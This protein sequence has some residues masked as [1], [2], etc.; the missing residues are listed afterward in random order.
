MLEQAP[1]ATAAAATTTPP[2]EQD[3]TPAA[4]TTQREGDRDPYGAKSF[5]A[6]LAPYDL[7]KIGAVNVM[8]IPTSIAIEALLIPTVRIPYSL[9]HKDEPWIYIG[10]SIQIGVPGAAMSVPVVPVQIPGFPLW[11]P[12]G[13]GDLRTNTVPGMVQRG[14]NRA[15]VQFW[16]EMLGKE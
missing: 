3:A 9:F 14:L 10:P 4:T 6:A 2:T 8:A 15:Y 12:P 1:D 7:L 11:I 16:N 13:P 5:A